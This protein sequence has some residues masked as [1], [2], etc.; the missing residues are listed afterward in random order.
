LQKPL[1]H[2][3]IPLAQ[4]LKTSLARAGAR[5]HVRSLSPLLA[6]KERGREGAHTRT[7]ASHQHTRP[8][9]RG[10]LE[11]SVSRSSGLDGFISL[12]GAKVEQ[13]VF[14]VVY[15]LH[16]GVELDSI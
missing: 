10:H 5:A 12:R 6:L 9:C 4:M 11:I 16:E 8:W 13:I 3:L 2:P 1:P 14:N 7:F 15:P